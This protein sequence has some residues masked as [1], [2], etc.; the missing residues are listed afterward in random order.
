MKKD[1]K[2]PEL[3]IVKFSLTDVLS[4]SPTEDPIGENIGGGGSGGSGGS[5]DF[6]GL[7]GDL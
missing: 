4:G 6:G 7:D 2:A 1:Y 5:G 3:E